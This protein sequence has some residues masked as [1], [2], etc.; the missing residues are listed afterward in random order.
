MI[1][2]DRLTLRGQEAVQSAIE[3]AEKHQNQQVEPEH[4]LAAMMGQ[5]EGVVRPILGKIG[6]QPQIILNEVEQAIE[7]VPKVSGG[8][9]FF[10]PRFSDVF[11]AAQKYAEGMNDDFVST[12][13]VLLAVAEEKAGDAGKILRSNG[14]TKDDIQKVMDQIRGGTRITDANAEENYQALE[15]YSIDLTE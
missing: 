5:E 15:K 12:E 10:S 4:L 8:Q 6:A 9:Q 13:H 2:L 7:R 14:V 3:I 11:N 1:R